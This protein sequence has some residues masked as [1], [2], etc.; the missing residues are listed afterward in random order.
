MTRIPSLGVESCVRNYEGPRVPLQAQMEHD[1]R[2]L[3]G[4]DASDSNRR[5][6]TRR[7][8]L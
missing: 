4:C 5:M 7:R 2:C 3:G 1:N 8:Q 6:L